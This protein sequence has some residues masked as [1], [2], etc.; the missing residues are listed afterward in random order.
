MLSPCFIAPLPLRFPGPTA[1]CAAARPAAGLPPRQARAA[2]PTC[3]APA[4]RTAAATCALV[5]T[6]ANVEAVLAEAKGE[7]GA[8]FGNSAENLGVGITGDVALAALDGPM[9]TLRLSGRFWHKRA[10]VLARVAAYLTAR[11]PEICQVDIEDA[12][13]LDDSEEEGARV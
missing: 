5:L 10:D 11:I 3:G 2:A 12:R 8:V 13:Q 1:A 7:L 4:R 9:V 6:E